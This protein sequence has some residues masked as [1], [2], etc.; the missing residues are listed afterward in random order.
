MIQLLFLIAVGAGLL[1]LLYVVMRRTPT[2]AEGSGGALV[3]AKH[4]L[5]AL[6]GGL[7]PA[8]SIG[9]VFGR[10]DLAYIESLGSRELRDLFLTERKRLALLWIGEVREQVDG[11]KHFHT[12][13]SRLFAH[14]S[15]RTELSLALDFVN[16]QVQT[17][18]LQMLMQW[19]GPYAAPSLVRRTASRAAGICATLDESLAFLTPALPANF[20]SSSGADG[21]TV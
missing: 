18:V 3:A 11:L 15:R 20:G 1:A 5:Q 8:E 10:H 19:Q 14:M 12:R 16:L 4:S 6:Q 17:R 13:R 21:T 7:L 9:R 2:A